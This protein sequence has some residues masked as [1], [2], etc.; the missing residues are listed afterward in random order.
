VTPRIFIVDH[1]R[2][3][4]D[5]LV[6]A[7]ANAASLRVTPTRIDRMKMDRISAVGS[8]GSWAAELG[9]KQISLR[10]RGGTGKTVILLQLAYS[11]YVRGGSRSLVLTYN[12]ALAAD[13]RRLL[14]L[15]GVVD[16]YESS[17]V[18]VRTIDSFLRQAMVELGV[19]QGHDEEF[20][21]RLP[22]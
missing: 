21:Q 14:S 5:W 16:P 13:L 8:L 22:E 15:L 1:F 3:H 18:A 10:G 17:C 11:A 20:F 9:R 4:G 2:Q 7:A 19:V 6:T 12:R